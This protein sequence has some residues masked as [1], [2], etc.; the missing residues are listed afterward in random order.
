MTSVVFTGTAAGHHALLN[1]MRGHLTNTAS[2]VSVAPGVNAGNGGV[3]NTSFTTASVP[4]IFTLTCTTAA[5][6]GGAFSVVG[7]VTGAMGDATVGVLFSHAQISFT[8][9][10]GSVD[11]AVSDSFTLTSV[12][13]E[14][15]RFVDGATIKESYM[16]APGLADTDDIYINMQTYEIGG[17]DTFNMSFTGA[18]NFDTLQPFDGQPG[19]SPAVYKT[20]WQ[21]DIDYWLIV[22]GRR[23]IIVVKIAGIFFASYCGFILPGGTSSEYPYPLYIG[24]ACDESTRR[25]SEGTYRLSNFWMPNNTS[26]YYRN[27]DGS[28]LNFKSVDVSNGS[29]T[30]S[31]ITNSIFPWY[32]RVYGTT[33]VDGSY[34]MIP[35]ILWVGS[36]ANRRV[37]GEFE[38]IQYVSGFAQASEDVLQVA[39]YANDF[40]V[41]QNTYRTDVDQFAAIELG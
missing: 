26:A 18:T 1:A 19:T 12:G 21:N 37:E 13:W 41:V 33:N 10:D 24:G 7:S 15:L 25:Y 29:S 4:Q 39:G 17:A 30:A 34:G 11:F 40:L 31:N 22:N 14:E 8:I 3:T 6:D 20:L 36:V 23:F 5:V 2:G 28:W 16:R 35:N 38:G 27:T 32:Q 9:A